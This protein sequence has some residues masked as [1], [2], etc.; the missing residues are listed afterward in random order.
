MGFAQIVTGTIATIGFIA[1]VAA[2]TSTPSTNPSATP[3]NPF[4]QDNGNS[5]MLN[6]VFGV[7]AGLILFTWAAKWCEKKYRARQGQGNGEREV[8]L[9][10][11][12]NV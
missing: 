1:K 2:Q 6:T 3:S 4:Q 9:L 12:N 7:S 8:P 5:K 11:N 10:Q